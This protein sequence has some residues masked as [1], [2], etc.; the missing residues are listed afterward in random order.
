VST[1]GETCCSPEGC[2]ADEGHHSDRPACP[3]CGAVGRTVAEETL[4]SIL[5][6]GRGE[7]LFG[8]ACR[9]CRTAGCAV[10]YYASG[11]LFVEKEAASVRVGLKETEEPRL[12][13]Y[14]FG[15]TSGEVQRQVEETGA[16]TIPAR[17]T[18]EI[19]AGRCDCK[20]KNPSG[21][22]CLGEAVAAVKAAEAAK[23]AE[24]AMAESTKVARAAES[25]EAAKSAEAAEA[26]E[27][28]E[29]AKAAEVAA[30]GGGPRH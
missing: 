1:R 7:A 28:V 24:S 22:C 15:F 10:L 25:A 14:C 21:A 9:F 26:A 3:R 18:A 29:A 13:C 11:G 6:P 16:S 17:I 8:A 5:K 19:Q 2:T 20:R 30:S 27:A 4:R 23:M 12:L